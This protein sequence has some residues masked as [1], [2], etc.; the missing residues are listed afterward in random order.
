MVCSI[1]AGRNCAKSLMD[2]LLTQDF[3]DFGDGAAALSQIYGAVITAPPAPAAAPPV[4]E[5]PVA[6]VPLLSSQPLASLG[7]TGRANVYG[8]VIDVGFAT[9]S[10]GSD[11]FNTVR[12]V[13]L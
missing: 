5:P 12:D 11:Y 6:A 13:Q 4:V 8:V 1:A 9:R 10:N 3:A 2:G 7:A